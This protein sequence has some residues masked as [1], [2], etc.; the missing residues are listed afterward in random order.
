MSKFKIIFDDEEQ[1]E[2]FDTREEAEEYAQYL[3]SCTRTGAEVLYL[4]NPGDNPYDEETFEEPEYEI[5]EV[6]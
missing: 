6:K 3:C 2:V 5:I 1:D 4:S